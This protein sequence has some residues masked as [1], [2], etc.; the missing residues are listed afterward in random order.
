MA[1]IVSGARLA[2]SYV[3][4]SAALEKIL[5]AGALVAIKY[6]LINRRLLKSN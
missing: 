5:S 3:I 4:T 6:I 2:L 1:R